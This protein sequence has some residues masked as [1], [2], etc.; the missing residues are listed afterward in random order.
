M[1]LFHL[2]RYEMSQLLLS[3]NGRHAKT[4]KLILQEAWAKSH[5]DMIEGGRSLGAFI[6]T[7][8]PT[9]F[10][11]VMKLTPCEPGMSL[12]DIVAL[13]SQ[14]EYNHFAVTAVQNWVK[15]D[16][17]EIIG[18]PDLGKKYSMEQAA[19]LFIIE[20]L[21]AALDLESIRKL[22][23]LIFHEAGSTARDLIRPIDLY[24]GYSGIFEEMDQNN[25]QVLD[26][27]GQG[28]SDKKHDHLVEILI[29]KKADEF[30]GGVP[31]LSPQQQEAV[32]NV[33]VIALLSVQTTYFQTL[34]KRF[35][36][37]SL[38]LHNL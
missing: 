30:A 25:D 12:N 20:D 1:E 2:T 28:R 24:A 34:A 15:R 9:I 14:I 37:A 26:L 21:R 13:G 7:S 5:K 19:L 16:L 17:R 22:L 35:L 18:S 33:T 36:N 32:S 23:M 31:A 11:K 10:E 27:H 4:P 6:S 38:F 29:K 3:L 8:L